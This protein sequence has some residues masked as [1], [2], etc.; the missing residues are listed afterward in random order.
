MGP[1]IKP[2]TWR[3][4][5]SSPALNSM[6]SQG[7]CPKNIGQVTNSSGIVIIFDDLLSKKLHDNNFLSS[8]SW[9]EVKVTKC[10][11]FW[12]PCKV[13]NSTSFYW[14]AEIDNLWRYF[15]DYFNPGAIC[16]GTGTCWPWR[17]RATWPSSRTTRSKRGCR[18]TSPNPAGKAIWWGLQKYITKPGR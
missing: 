17:I 1:Q 13:R 9:L 14:T 5:T 12:C 2:S 18:N 3:V 6:C 8:K 15:A 7:K 4:T 16:Y 10:A 11:V